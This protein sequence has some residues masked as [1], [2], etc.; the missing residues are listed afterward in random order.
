MLTRRMNLSGVLCVCT[1]VKAGFVLF[2]V[3]GIK[4]QMSNIFNELRISFIYTVN[5]HPSP[6][7]IGAY[8]HTSPHPL[9]EE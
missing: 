5:F 2:M 7:H 9:M 8:K 1:R 6:S 4:E 3:L